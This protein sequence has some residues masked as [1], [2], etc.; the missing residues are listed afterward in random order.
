MVV[1]AASEQRRGTAL[2][3]F[4]A[5]FDIGM[6]LGAPL[7]GATVALFGYAAGFWVGAAFALAG[8]LLTAAGGWQREPRAA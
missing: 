1:E 3:G 8:A 2:G 6:G 4:T 5:F 7:V